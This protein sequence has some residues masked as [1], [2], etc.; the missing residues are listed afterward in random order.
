MTGPKPTTN[1]Q[2]GDAEGDEDR[3]GDGRQTVNSRQS[4]HS[5]R[6]N[7]F[8][9]DSVAVSVSVSVSVSASVCDSRPVDKL[10]TVVG[11]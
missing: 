8:A 1:G 4:K 10:L 3:A 9:S 11:K 5:M 7:G 6:V 2:H